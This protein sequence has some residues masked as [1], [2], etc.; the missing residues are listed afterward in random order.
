MES[1]DESKL[2]ERQNIGTINPNINIRIKE[3]VLKGKTP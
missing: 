3:S 2:E 1:I